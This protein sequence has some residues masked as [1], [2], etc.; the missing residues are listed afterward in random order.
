MASI[1][2]W[3]PLSVEDNW[4]NLTIIH[5]LFSRL[6]WFVRRL[7][8]FVIRHEDPILFALSEILL[9]FI[10][11]VLKFLR[12]APFVWAL[13]DLA[14]LFRLIDILTDDL[15]AIAESLELRSG[16]S[17]LLIGLAA[18]LLRAEML[19]LTLQERRIFCLWQIGT[20]GLWSL[21]LD[22]KILSKDV[23]VDNEQEVLCIPVCGLGL[24]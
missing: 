24:L 17:C 6:V 12:V 7:E 19:L 8:L 2:A 21:W 16:G 1:L 13:N 5:Y 18:G 14:T 23:S 22:L 10:V 9:H 11:W 20:L 3:F 15:D 4:L